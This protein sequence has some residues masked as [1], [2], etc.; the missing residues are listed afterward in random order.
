M[1]KPH[2]ILTLPEVAALLKVA[3]RTLYT[4][5]QNGEIPCF[6]V[7]GQWRFRRADL[8]QW[9]ASKL[10]SKIKMKTRTTDHG[11]APQG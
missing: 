5:A 10:P 7:R 1:K 11:Q 2:P 9:I 8:D 4:M 6:K 3:E